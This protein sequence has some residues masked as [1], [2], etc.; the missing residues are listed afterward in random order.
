MTSRRVSALAAALVLSWVTSQGAFAAEPPGR[1]CVQL[2]AGVDA[3]DGAGYLAAVRIETRKDDLPWA[4]VLTSDSACRDG[5]HPVLLVAAGA[6]TLTLPDRSER[7]YALDDLPPDTRPRT[8]ARLVVD[9]LTHDLGAA[10]PDL[11]LLHEALGRAPAPVEVEPVAASPSS[12]TPDTPTTEAAVSAPAS[13]PLTPVMGAGP[14]WTIRA[15]GGYRYHFGSRRHI[16][17]PSLETGLTLYDGRLTLTL[18]GGYS[19]GDGVSDATVRATLHGGELLAIARAG[20]GF[21]AFA[22]RGGLGVG[23]QRRVLR[24]MIEDRQVSFSETSDVA[25]LSLEAELLWR[26]AEGWHVGL[27]VDGRGYLGGAASGVLRQSLDG[28]LPLAVGG[29]LALGLDL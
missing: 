22:L 10:A 3:R 23:W 24:G 4:W 25:V 15:A 28:E 26:F 8:L 17:G 2:A 18:G 11:P 27:A 14:T 21:G 6:A 5:G 1:G 16:G 19:T 13:T 7:R 29:E 9:A 12:A 20:A